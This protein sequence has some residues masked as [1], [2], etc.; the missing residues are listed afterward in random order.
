MTMWTNQQIE[1]QLGT[2]RCVEL[3]Q[4]I[5]LALCCD[6]T[7]RQVAAHVLWRNAASLI[8]EAVS[9]LEAA[10]CGRKGQK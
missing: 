9:E 1:A 7:N 8:N 3:L 6:A 4:Y 5:S 2:K 10:K